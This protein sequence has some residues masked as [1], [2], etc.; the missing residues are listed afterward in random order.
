MR[1]ILLFTAFWLIGSSS[2]ARSAVTASDTAGHGILVMNA[3]DARDTK[4]RNNKKELFAELADS[5]KN[6]LYE[7]L[8]PNNEKGVTILPEL[9][10][11]TSSGY[12]QTVLDQHGADIILAI[13]SLNVFFEQTDVSVSKNNDGS[14]S[15]D[16]SYDLCCTVTYKI[17]RPGTIGSASEERNCRFFTNR[18]VAS[19]LLA[20]GPDVVG[21]KKYTYSVVKE[22]A[23]NFISRN[24]HYL[25]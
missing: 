22:N 24:L 8:A 11:N 17:Y 14:K 15:R 16:A 10:T 25:Q 6:Y 21:K 4:Y 12:L 23:F 2:S 13:L 19:G 7:E 20:G 3:F 5:L 9:Q 18:N 1:P